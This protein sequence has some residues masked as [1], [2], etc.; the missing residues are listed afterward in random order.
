MRKDSA[1][2]IV[3]EKKLQ[4]SFPYDFQN[5]PHPRISGFSLIDSA[6]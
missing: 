4:K 1:C 5:V 6:H 2:D 3:K